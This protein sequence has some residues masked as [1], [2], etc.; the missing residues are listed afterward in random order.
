MVR[1]QSRDRPIRRRLR[2]KNL[3]KNIAVSQSA[4]LP[5]GRLDFPVPLNPGSLS[6]QLSPFQDH[7]RFREV[8]ACL[9]KS[10]IPGAIRPSIGLAVIPP[11]IQTNRMSISRPHHTS[12][13]TSQWASVWMDLREDRGGSLGIPRGFH[14]ID[15]EKGSRRLSNW[16]PPRI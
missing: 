2:L 14:I 9:F 1:A 4:R 12:Q 15:N 7:L 13:S 16:I 11:S 6:H 10:P 3:S 8:P 5:A